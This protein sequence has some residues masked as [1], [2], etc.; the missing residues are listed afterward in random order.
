MHLRALV[1][2]SVGALTLV[3]SS[4]SRAD[5][6]GGMQSPAAFGIGLFLSGLGAAG[7]ATGGYFFASSGEGCANLDRD[8]VPTEGE[9]AGCRSDV[10]QRVGGVIGLVAGGAF[11][12]GGVPLIV[13]GAT[14]ED[15]RPSPRVTFDVGPTSGRLRVEF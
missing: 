4:P 7:L 15:E 8:R 11:L 9:I 1:A 10:N 14:P 5:E 6:G 12:L 3:A 13:V 2:A